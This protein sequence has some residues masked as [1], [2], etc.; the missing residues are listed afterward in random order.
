MYY[1]DSW[2]SLEK[3][4]VILDESASYDCIYS[5]LRRLIKNA[6]DCD[7]TRAFRLLRKNPKRII[8]FWTNRPD[9]FN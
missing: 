4:Y 6:L 8:D 3:R 7:K 5:E 1:I 9:E 2:N